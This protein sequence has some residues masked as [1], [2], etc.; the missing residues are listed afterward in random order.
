MCDEVRGDLDGVDHPILRVSRVRVEPDERH[1][2]RVGGKAFVLEFPACAPVHRVGVSGAEC[3]DVEVQGAT[4]DLLVRREG[5]LDWPVRDCAV[6]HQAFGGGHDFRDTSLVVGAEQ[7]RARGGDDIVSKPLRERRTVRGPKHGMRVVWKDEVAAVV[8]PVHDR[9]DVCA[10]QL[11]RGV[12][13]G[14][15]GDRRNV[16]PRSR[17]NRRRYVPGLVHGGVDEPEPAQFVGQIV[18]QNELPVRTRVGR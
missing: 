11:R 8:L 4:A 7:R 17:W 14:D 5:D 2:H 1:R 3:L 6:G 18:Q 15:K 10:C 16:F 9:L 13:M 12:H